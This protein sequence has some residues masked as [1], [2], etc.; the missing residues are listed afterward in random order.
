M[1]RGSWR[2]HSPQEPIGFSLWVSRGYKLCCRLLKRGL[3]EDISMG[4]WMDI[5]EKADLRDHFSGAH[6]DSFPPI[7]AEYWNQ[8]RAQELTS[9]LN[10]ASQGLAEVSLRGVVEEA[11]LILQEAL[12]CPPHI[13]HHHL[14]SQVGKGRFLTFSLYIIL[15][16]LSPGKL[17]SAWPLGFSWTSSLSRTLRAQVPRITFLRAHPWPSCRAGHPSSP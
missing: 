14:N 12:V 8:G 16:V 5:R 13:I 2:G 6:G 15:L 17:L 4:L 9:R 3:S 11:I 10:T 1:D 7:E